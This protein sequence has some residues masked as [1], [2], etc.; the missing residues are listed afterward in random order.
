MYGADL[1]DISISG[2]LWATKFQILKESYS[3]RNFWARLQK[4]CL[5]YLNTIHVQDIGLVCYLNSSLC[6]FM[7]MSD[8]YFNKRLNNVQVF[9]KLLIEKSTPT[10]LAY[11]NNML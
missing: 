10:T 11:F 6:P 3:F 9:Y 7:C 4:Y 5:Y 1:A 2:K 8:T